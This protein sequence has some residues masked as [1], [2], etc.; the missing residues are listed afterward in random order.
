MMTNHRSNPY[1]HLFTLFK[2]HH[3]KHG[4]YPFTLHALAFWM[5]RT[6]MGRG[7]QA[8]RNCCLHGSPASSSMRSRGSSCCDTCAAVRPW[9]RWIF[10]GYGYWGM[11]VEYMVKD[12]FTCI[13]YIYIYRYMISVHNH[14][15]FWVILVG[16]AM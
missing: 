8:W 9:P 12:E 7:P 15:I 3:G 13:I 16:D 10:R 5:L 11:M 1:L 2:V 6:S 4:R 14:W